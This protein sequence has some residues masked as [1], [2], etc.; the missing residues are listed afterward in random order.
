MLDDFAYVL[1]LLTRSD[2]QRVA[3]IH[4]YQIVDAHSSHKFPRRVDIIAAGI[5]HEA[6]VAFEHVA[7]ISRFLLQLMLI[8]RC[9][10]AQVVPSKFG[11]N[12]EQIR[13]ML[14]L[15]RTRLSYGVIH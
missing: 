5:E 12:A 8:Q 6:G 15:R 2:E 14:A 7:P 4:Y 10:G 3:G 13:G 9:P 11:R 1:R